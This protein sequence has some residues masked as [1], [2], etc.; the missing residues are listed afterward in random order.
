MLLALIAEIAGEPVLLDPDDRSR[1]VRENTWWL[2]SRGE[3][4]AREVARAWERTASRIRERLGEAGGY[5]GT[6]TFYLWHD[7]QAGRLCCSTAS[8]PADG[9]PFAGAYRLT[10]DPGPVVE[11]FLHGGWS[12][13][14]PVWARP[15]GARAH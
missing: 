13:P 15:V 5:R 9:L 8:L 1:E 7:A 12:D 4:P 3:P 6:A 2:G 11:E 10:D 14:F